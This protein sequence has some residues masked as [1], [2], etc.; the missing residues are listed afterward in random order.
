MISGSSAI[1]VSAG[2]SAERDGY[3]EG[4]Y[5]SIPCRKHLIV[6]NHDDDQVKALPWD[7]TQDMATIKDGDQRFT[8]CHYPMITW[9]GARKGAIRLFGH[10]HERWR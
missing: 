1:S 2:R 9:E 4:L 6:G 8:L 5:H 3:L 10:V 7:S